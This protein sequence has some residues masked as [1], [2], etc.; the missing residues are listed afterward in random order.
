[1][2]K[3]DSKKFFFFVIVFEKATIMIT[4]IK[5]NIKKVV[6]NPHMD[7]HFCVKFVSNDFL[8]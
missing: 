1:V 7:L 4:F 2:G 3:L 8:G 6:Q 5:L